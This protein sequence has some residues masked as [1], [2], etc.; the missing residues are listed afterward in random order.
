MHGTIMVSYK[1]LCKADFHKE[2]TLT[3]LLENEKIAKVIKNELAKGQRNLTLFEGLEGSLLK[4]E[5][6]KEIHTFEIQKDDFADI[7][8]LAEED[9]QNKKLIKKECDRIEL[10]DI[11]TR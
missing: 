6:L 11:E 5:T 9:A 10:V 3:K 7:L 1:I 8:D 4:I 2:V